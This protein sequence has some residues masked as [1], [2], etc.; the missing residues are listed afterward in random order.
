MATEM[1]TDPVLGDG[2]L[3]FGR[4]ERAWA[5]FKKEFGPTKSHVSIL[6][7]VVNGSVPQHQRDLYWEIEAWY[8]KGVQEVFEAIRREIEDDEVLRSWLPPGH[9]PSRQQLEV[10]RNMLPSDQVANR[11]QLIGIDVR[12]PFLQPG[13]CVLRYQFDRNEPDW[14]VRIGEDFQVEWAGLAD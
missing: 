10:L 11:L 4:G 9:V 2:D 5:S 3:F 14:I 13:K 7:S 1:L 6:A 8:P 12:Y